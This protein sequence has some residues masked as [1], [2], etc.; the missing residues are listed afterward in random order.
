MHVRPL[1]HLTPN[2]IPPL[3]ATSSAPQV[4]LIRFESGLV[5]FVC[6]VPGVSFGLNLLHPFEPWG[7]DE[8]S[9]GP[10]EDHKLAGADMA[11]SSDVLMMRCSVLQMQ[12]DQ[13]IADVRILV[14]IDTEP[15]SA[16]QR[17]M[18]MEEQRTSRRFT[19]SAR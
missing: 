15:G 11:I 19:T 7:S 6:P 12:S 10:W 17:R 4:T 9:S 18:S 2:N 13:T 3:Q 5:Y 1:Q 8:L 14:Q 16:W